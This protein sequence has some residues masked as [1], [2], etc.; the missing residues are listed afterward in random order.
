MFSRYLKKVFDEA[1]RKT[2]VGILEM[3]DTLLL[4][5]QEE[6]LNMKQRIMVY[7]FE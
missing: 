6:S 2:L 1:G 7:N 3:V 5:I 4:K